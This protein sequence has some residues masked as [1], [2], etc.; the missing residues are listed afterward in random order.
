VRHGQAGLGEVIVADGSTGVCGLLCCSLWK[1]VVAGRALVSCGAARRGLVRQGNSCRRQQGGRK[2]SLLLS[3]ESR[4]GT[5]WIGRLRTGAV[6][7][8]EVIAADGSTG[9]FGLLCCFHKGVVMVRQSLVGHGKARSGH[10][11]C[12]RVSGALRRPFKLKTQPAP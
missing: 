9:A 2:P 8:G 7:R 11:W 1:V 10:A 5:A 12:G 3:L 6:W 4:L